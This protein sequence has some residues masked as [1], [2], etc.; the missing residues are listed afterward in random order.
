MSGTS[1][2][3]V[4][5]PLQGPARSSRRVWK[6]A[7]GFVLLTLLAGGAYYSKQHHDRNKLAADVRA[8]GGVYESH[9][10]G[11]SLWKRIEV[12]RQTGGW[13]V[14][15]SRVTIAFVESAVDDQWIAQ[16]ASALSQQPNLALT[17]SRTRIT[18]EAL[19]TIGRCSNLNYLSL[20]GADVTDQ[21]LMKLGFIP[22]L[23]RLDIRD[24]RMTDQGLACLSQL[25]NLYALEINANQA[26]PSG[27]DQMTRC[28]KLGYLVLHHANDEVIHSLNQ[29]PQLTTLAVEGPEVTDASLEAL[30]NRQ[31]LEYLM[32]A[33]CSISEEGIVQLKQ[34]LGASNVNVVR[35]AEP[36]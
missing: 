3:R 6:W 21:G 10:G 15:K 13:L 33:D 25:P 27:I 1:D 24:T 26:T 29:L 12:F 14:D 19:K 4:D 2:E 30:L 17:L 32:L 23:W 7:V 5:L 36:E 35:S 8:A 18:D 9:R 22:N 16:H 34:M 28:R 20:R 11:V 31:R